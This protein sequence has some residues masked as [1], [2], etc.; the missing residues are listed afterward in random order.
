MLI[1]L[2]AGTMPGC[3]CDTSAAGPPAASADLLPAAAPGVRSLVL[4]DRDSSARVCPRRRYRGRT[5]PARMNAGWTGQNT[6]NG[7]CGTPP[8][9][10][11]R[12]GDSPASTA[13]PRP[14]RQV[15]GRA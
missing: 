1:A 2:P 13:T 7:S 12:D 3:D 4:V 9:D 14:G 5:P 15:A 8:D 10:R 11:Q 6:R